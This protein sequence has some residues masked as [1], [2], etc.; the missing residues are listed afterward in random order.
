MISFELPQRYV[1]ALDGYSGC[2]K[3]TL[4]KDIASTLNVIFID[5]G[6]M[7]R[8]VTLLAMRNSM[9]ENNEIKKEKLVAALNGVTID[10]R[11]D[12]NIP[13]ALHLNGE[14]IE[15]EIRKPEVAA[16]VSHV[17]AISE[18]R[19]FLV[20]QQRFLGRNGR[21]VLDG[22]DIGTVVFPDANIKFFVTAQI[23]VRAQRRYNEMIAKGIQT[24][25]E[26]VSA[27]LAER[28][29]ID[30][31][32]EDSPLKQAADAIVIDNSFLSVEE[33][34]NLALDFIH[35]NIQQHG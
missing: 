23:P 15:S 8:A 28:D 12:A 32:R 9:V 6:A 11:P 27:S 5:T 17:A 18:V 13:N 14:N 20:A 16:L 29:R 10:F 34:L 4:A 26:E 24:T 22:R 1:I 3:S 30:T 2:G 35:K 33:Q 21:V 7:Y 31:T 19:S 25:L